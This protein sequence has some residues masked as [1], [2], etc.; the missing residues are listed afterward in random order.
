MTFLRHHCPGLLLLFAFWVGSAGVSNC[1]A[2]DDNRLLPLPA[3]TPQDMRLL[4][5]EPEAIPLGG[6]LWP[7]GLDPNSLLPPETSPTRQ[8]PDGLL[9]DDPPGLLSTK[10]AEGFLLFIPKPRPLATGKAPPNAHPLVEVNADFLKQCEELEAEGS[11]LDP[12]SLLAETASEDLRR[13]LAFHAGESSTPA[14]FLLLD[15]DEQLPASA[16]LSRMGRGRLALDRAC[17]TVYPLAEPWRAR[18]FMTREIINGIPPEYLRGIL[19]ACIR[20]AMRASDP[21]EQLQRFATQL[22]LRLIWMERAYPHIFAA[23]EKPAASESETE[24][25]ATPALSEIRS[26]PDPAPP[27][28]PPFYVRWQSAVMIT[29]GVLAGLLVLALFTRL[30]LRWRRRRMRNSVWILPELET[31]PRFGGPHCGQGGVWIRYG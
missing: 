7:D 12:H 10:H 9:D 24:S 16:D 8:P 15:S 30:L 17:L 29:G 4:R 2:E 22:S 1:G 14:N 11:L 3:W 28:K 27:Q 21:V 25:P 19:H 13:L 6:Y 18:I 20:D 31:K 5:E 26:S 23:A